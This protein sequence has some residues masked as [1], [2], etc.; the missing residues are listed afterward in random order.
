RLA[1]LAGDASL[2]NAVGA[3]GALIGPDAQLLMLKTLGLRGSAGLQPALRPSSARAEAP[4]YAQTL[5]DLVA[6]LN[7][8]SSA[9]LPANQR[10]FLMHEVADLVEANPWSRGA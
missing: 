9:D 4:R 10:R 2:R 1:E 3:Q 7:D 8:Y 6:R 5:G